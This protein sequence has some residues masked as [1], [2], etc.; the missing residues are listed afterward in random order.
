[1][2]SHRGIF[3][4]KRDFL[5]NRGVRETTIN[6]YT[7][8][9][10]F[11]IILLLGVGFTQAQEITEGTFVFT[12]KIT[13][14]ANG[15]SMVVEG[16]EEVVSE[17]FEAE[18]KGLTNK[19]PKNVKQDVM[20]MEAMQVA[21]FSNATLDYYYRIESLG[22]EMPGFTRIN[23]FL[24]AGNY[25]FLSSEKYPKEMDAAKSWLQELPAHLEVFRNAQAVDE[26]EAMIVKAEK[27]L[28][29]LQ[30]DQKKLEKEQMD[31]DR[32][33]EANEL[34]QKSQTEMIE[35]EKAKLSSMKAFLEKVK[36]PDTNK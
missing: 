18:W 11:F 6:T 7:M 8:K 13:P 12:K 4:H 21:R 9:R 22:K 25:N 5:K 24:S 36:G 27:E 2:I 16:N 17:W 23:L 29:N 33:K 1:M 20:G 28:K 30:T 14:S 15:L 19:K 10:L 26:Q 31:L 32:K 35:K 3:F 34:Q